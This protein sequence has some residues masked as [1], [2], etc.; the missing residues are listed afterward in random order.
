MLF[1]SK[2]REIDHWIM[3]LAITLVILIFGPKMGSDLKEGLVI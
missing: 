1:R 3:L 2:S